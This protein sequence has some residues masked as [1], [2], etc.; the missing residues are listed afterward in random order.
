M[1]NRQKLVQ[2]QFLNNEEAV[3]KRLKTVYNQALKDIT[4]QSR[5]FQADIN[6]LQVLIDFEE[7]EAKR[8]TLKS[9]QQSK[10]Y[11]KQYQDALKKQINSILDTMQVEE[12]KTVDEYLKKCYEEGFIG[13]MYDLQGQGI[14][15]CMPLDQEAMVRAVQTDSKISQG[16]YTRLGE[17]VDLLK[18]KITAQVS[19]GISTGMTWQQVAKQLSNYTKIGYNNAVRIART[20]GH[21]VQVQSAMDAC[22]NAKDMGADVVKQWDAALDKRTRASHAKVDGEIRELDEPFSNGLM[23]PSDPNGGASEV[24]N[25][26]CALLQRA[27]WA[28]DDEELETLKKRAEYYGLD[29]TKNFDDYKEKYLKAVEDWIPK[30]TSAMK[31]DPA[32]WK[33]RFEGAKKAEKTSNVVNGKNLVGEIDYND[34]NFNY[35]IEKA[36]NVQGFDG[37]PKVVSNEEF[38]EALKKSNIYGERIYSASTQEIL[39]AYRNELYTGKWYV[40]CSEGGSKYGQGMYCSARFENGK[41]IIP[42]DNKI[43]WEMMGYQDNSEKRGNFFHYVEGI[44]LEPDAKI[45]T[46]YSDTTDVINRYSY[47]YA[48]KN[49]SSEETKKMIQELIDLE[50]EIAIKS[51]TNFTSSVDWDEID[52]LYDRRNEIYENE[53]YMNE[54]SPLT[55]K[56]YEL[57]KGKDSSVL[58]IEMGYDAINAQGRGEGGSYTVILNRTKVI[59]RKG[60]SRLGNNPI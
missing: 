6:E 49:A 34:S 30:K 28:L 44:T 26:R 4:E 17:D 39:D 51:N 46:L 1:N 16:L 31:R 3:I 12:F 35:D 7:D 29:K 22:Y 24:V 52:K 54:I 47:E 60:G 50:E 38:E 32:K 55:S 13:T 5:K 45:L 56:A 48:K 18:R 57:S 21:R 53:A 19:R 20:E 15:L 36:M 23:F 43:G 37:L 42:H 25:C 27:R 59:F 10:I 2:Q 40:D 33:E 11:Q 14:P 58:A 41:Y 9:M 8:A